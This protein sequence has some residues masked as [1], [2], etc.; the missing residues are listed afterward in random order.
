MEGLTPDLRALI[1]WAQGYSRG[2]GYF[3]HPRNHARAGPKP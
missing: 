2:Y 3:S 1:E